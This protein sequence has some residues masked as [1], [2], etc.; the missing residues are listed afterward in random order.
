MYLKRNNKL[1]IITLY[2]TNYKA[3]FYLRQLSKLTKIPLKTCQSA[4]SELEKEKVLTSKTEGKNKYF[5]LNINN[6]RTKSYL[7]RSEIYHTEKF[8]E[9][10]PEV[11]MFL[12]SIGDDTP[13]IVFG[14]F[15]IFKADKH[16]DMDLL[17][18]SKK[19]NIPYHLLPFKLHKINL[20]KK[21]FRKALK[22]Q[23]TLIK[24]I[25]EK[26]I[27][28][29]NPSFYINVMWGYYGKD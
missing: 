11:K 28:L 7:L 12:K 16:S 9:K 10:Y 26:H 5:S 21:Q 27:I 8:A 29:N 13:I 19:E 3:S 25:Q 14:S 24:E 1:E 6:F 23:E 20:D 4:L 17:I 18:I 15:A 22:E 2:R